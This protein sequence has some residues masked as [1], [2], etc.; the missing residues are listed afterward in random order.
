MQINIKMKYYFSLSRMAIMK[1]MR[2][3]SDDK[4][5]EKLEILYFTGN[6]VK[7]SHYAKEPDISS[8]S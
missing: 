2:G 8:I 7:C 5:V 3:T 4:D 6:N 1:K